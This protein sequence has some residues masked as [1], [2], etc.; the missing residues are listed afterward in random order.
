MNDYEWAKKNRVDLL[1]KF[2]IGDLDNEVIAWTIKMR[3]EALDE[4]ILLYGNV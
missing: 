2:T 3:L 4:R 1:G